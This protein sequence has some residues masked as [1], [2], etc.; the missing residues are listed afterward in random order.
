MY[1]INLFKKI[2]YDDIK[3]FLLNYNYLL[4]KG[5]F[6]KILINLYLYGFINKNN[7]NK[8]NFL[9]VNKLIYSNFLKYFFKLYNFILKLYFFRLR[10]KGLGYRMFR[11]NKN[12]LKFFFAKN[13]YYY[14]YIPF[15][16]YVKI[17]RRNFFI[18]SFNKMLLNQLFH[19]F[20]LLKKLDL[21]EKTNSFVSKNKIL[22]LKKRK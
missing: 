18:I 5:K 2:L 1:Y 16:I 21:Y 17:R 14:F 15:Y 22:F 4:I 20:M 9:F 8:L 13:H 19:H 10:L 6:G 3:I 12:M 11:I 7:L